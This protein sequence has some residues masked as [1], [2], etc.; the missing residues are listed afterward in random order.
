MRVTQAILY[1][2]YIKDIMRMQ[3]S[4]YEESK[5]LSTGKDINQPSDDP[6]GVSDVLSSRS[7]LSS[8]SQYQKNIDST[9]LYL[10]TSEQALSSVKDVLSRI[11]ELTV[12][13]ATGTV[14]AGARTNTAIEVQSLFDQ[15]VSLGNTQVNNKYVFSGYLTSTAAFDSVGTYGGDTNKHSIKIDQNSTMSIG[16]NGGEV[17]SGVGGDIDIFQSVTDLITALNADDITNIQAAIGTLDTSF[18]QVSNAVADIGGKVSRINSA[19]ANL[20][21][22]V[23]RTRIHISDVEDANIAEVISNLQL[24]QVALEAALSSASKVFS[25]NIFNYL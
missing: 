16:L 22:L 11:Q 25:V 15:L 2:T 23:L 9:M 5:K 6:V 3:E 8:L 4:L 21:D 17:F 20:S 24:G 13:M 1:D 18:S 12:A 19:S 10:A 14:D 7:Q